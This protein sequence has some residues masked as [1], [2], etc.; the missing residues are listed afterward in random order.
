MH[1]SLSNGYIATLI[2]THDFYSAKVTVDVNGLGLRWV[3][4]GYRTHYQHYTKTIAIHFSFPIGIG[5]G[6]EIG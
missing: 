2:L 4:N 3:M 5:F 1:V 6:V